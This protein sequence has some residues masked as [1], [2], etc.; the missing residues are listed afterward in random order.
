MQQ[1]ERECFMDFQKYL[2]ERLKDP[3]TK[4]GIE[5]ELNKITLEDIINNI[6]QDTGHSKY[7]VEVLDFD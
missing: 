4:L 3:E 2:Q 5:E 6:L 7:R 1:L